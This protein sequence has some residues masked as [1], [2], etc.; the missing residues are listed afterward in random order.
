MKP[1]VTLMSATIISCAS[2]TAQ[3]TPPEKPN[4]QMQAVLDK[5]GTLGGK[6]IES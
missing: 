3:S 4:A 1:L 2:L 6:P 5:L